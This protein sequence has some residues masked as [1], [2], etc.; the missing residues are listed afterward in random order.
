MKNWFERGFRCILLAVI[1]S[2]AGCGRV[3]DLAYSEYVSIPGTGWDPSDILGFSPLPSDSTLLSDK[4]YNLILNIRYNPEC[5]A[6]EL[7]VVISEESE[8]GEIS[9]ETLSIPLHDDNGESLGKKGLV[10]Y[11]LSYTLSTDFRVP[12]GYWVEI[13]SMCPREY[14]K[15]ITDI[16]LSL[17]NTN[18][19]PGL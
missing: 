1:L 15:G 17:T 6:K 7:P 19:E 8:E 14:T 5:R 9:S 11:E 13:A 2:I 10:L 4:R 3:D 18:I 12:D 16:G